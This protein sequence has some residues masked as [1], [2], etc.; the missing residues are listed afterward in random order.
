[1]KPIIL[2]EDDSLIVVDKPSN[3]VVHQT[4]DTSRPHL[5]Q[6]LEENN[7]ELYL[8]NRLDKD[9]SG[10]V[11][12]AKNIDAANVYSSLFAERTIEKSYFA[13]VEGEVDFEEKTISNF[14]GPVKGMKNIYTSVRSG[15]KIAETNFKKV[16]ANSSFSLIQALPKTGRT[17]QIRVHLTELGYPIA[18]DTEYGAPFRRQFKRTM[19]HASSI[20]LMHPYTKNRLAISS[21]FPEDFQSSI[22]FLGL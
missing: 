1:M 12:I 18:G 3:L 22:S 15:G 7:R 2:Y 20:N 8:I 4:V 21:P 13:I 19:L 6:A 14:L 17:H 9:T 16:S 11:L 10:V 5:L